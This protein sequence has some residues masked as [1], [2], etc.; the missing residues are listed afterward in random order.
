MS[1]KQPTWFRDFATAIE[2]DEPFRL[3][4]PECDRSTLPP[5]SSCP[6]C[7]NDQLEK[8]QLSKNATVQSHSTVHVTIPRFLDETP[9]TVVLARF[10]E[11]ISLCGQLRGAE[12]IEI[13]DEVTL[14]VEGSTEDGLL[15]TFS[16]R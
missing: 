15:V 3:F 9:Y 5:R 10:D 14:G 16:P 6:S 13:D 11:G 2:E 4:C 1:S 7:P 12:D 8:K